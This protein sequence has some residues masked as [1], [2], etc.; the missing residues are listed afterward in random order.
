MV[1]L[2]SSLCGCLPEGVYMYIYIYYHVV[3]KL[4]LAPTGSPFFIGNMDSP[5]SSAPSVHHWIVCIYIYISLFFG[6]LNPYNHHEIPWKTILNHHEIP[7]NPDFFYVNLHFSYGWNTLKHPNSHDKPKGE[8][9]VV[10]GHSRGTEAQI[11]RLCRE[12]SIEKSMGNP[13]NH[14]KT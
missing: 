8:G 3:G 12:K 14:G 5:S 7:L 9:I 10:Q 11:H 6:W 2:S 13:R 1:D 4:L